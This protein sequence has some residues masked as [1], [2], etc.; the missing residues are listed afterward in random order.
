VRQ[1][2]EIKVH[3]RI[4]YVKNYSLPVYFFLKNC[5]AVTM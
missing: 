5:I 4:L 1:L 3:N 2:T